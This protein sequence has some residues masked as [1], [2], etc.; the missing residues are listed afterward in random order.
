M[1]LRLL[2]TLALSAC[3]IHVA[4]DDGQRRGSRYAAK[5]YSAFAQP[6]QAFRTVRNGLGCLGGT[7]LCPNGRPSPLM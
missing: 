7:A 5:A 3:A 1:G 4:Q 6:I 2:T